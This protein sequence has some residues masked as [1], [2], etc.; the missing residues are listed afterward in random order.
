MTE[1]Q[2]SI[3][4]ARITDATRIATMSQ[5]LIEDG[6][7][8]AWRPARVASSIRN[9]EARVI[10]ACEAGEILGFA[11][12]RFGDESAHLDLFAVAPEV[13]RRGIGRRLLEWLEQCAVVAGITRIELEVRAGNAE[14]RAFYRRMQY[15]DVACLPGYY[16][17]RED[18]IRMRRELVA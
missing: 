5:R 10:V 17:R 18:A 2:I 3:T 15:R 1:P 6:L 13:H 12:M 9:R 11:I 14:G 16:E 7:D 8:W 4:L